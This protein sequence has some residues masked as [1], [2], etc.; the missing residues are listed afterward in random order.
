MFY[1]YFCEP[2]SR[3]LR[4]GGG[5]PFGPTKNGFR[6]CRGLDRHYAAH[7]HTL[8]HHNTTNRYT[9]S[10][11]VGTPVHGHLGTPANQCSAT[12]I[13]CDH[14]NLYS[15]ACRHH[16]QLD[17]TPCYALLST[18]LLEHRTMSACFVWPTGQ[19]ASSSPALCI[20]SD[21]HSPTPSTSI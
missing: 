9:L 17:T 8:S 12:E 5:R 15:D 11:H 10:Q 20:R 13:H 3:F 19:C 1:R 21:A 6:T 4:G 14:K 7:R 16:C 18:L 2:F